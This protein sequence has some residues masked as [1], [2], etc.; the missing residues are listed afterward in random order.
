MA[1]LLEG[2]RFLKNAAWR[3]MGNFLVPGGGGKNQER[4]ADWEAQVKKLWVKFATL[5][6]ISL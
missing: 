1:Y 5:K 4:N 2:N 6:P 3:R